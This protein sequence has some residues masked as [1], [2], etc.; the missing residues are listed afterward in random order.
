MVPGM[1]A[2]VWIG[3]FVLTAGVAHA[4]PLAHLDQDVDG[5]GKVDKVTIESSGDLIIQAATRSVLALRPRPSSAEL[6]AATV[7][8]TPMLSA[9]YLAPG[10]DET[11][12]YELRGAVWVQVLREATG[13]VP[14]D[15]DY[16]VA[17]VPAS[18][19]I[20][21][22][23]QRAG[24]HRCDGKPAYLFA[25]GWTGKKFQRL[26]KLPIEV[27]EPAAVLFAKPDP[28][29]PVAPLLYQARVASYEI[30]AQD[31]SALALPTELEDGNPA[32][33]WREELST[34]GEGQFFTF[35]PRAA[36]MKARELRFVAAA[37]KTSV[38]PRRVAVVGAKAAFHI[39]LADLEGAQSVTLPEPI[40]GCVSVV[41]ESAYGGDHGSLAIGELAVYG[42]G[43]RAGGGEATLAHVIAD[44]GDIKTAMQALARRGATAA[45]ALDTELE[46]A[47]SAGARTRL[48][49]ALGE[50]HDPAVGPL[51]EHAIAQSRVEEPELDATLA[52]MGARGFAQELHDLIAK[53][54]LA[55]AHRAAAARALAVA[56]AQDPKADPS[57]LID[58]AGDGS[59]DERK[60]V[61]EGLAR[62]PAPALLGA[63]AAATTPQ[64]AGDLYRAATRRARTTPAERPL[65]VA[66]FTAALA[67]TTDYERRYRLIDGLAA[68]GDPLALEL[69]AK[70]LGS[71]PSGPAGS[72]RFAL[73]HVAADAIAKSPRAEALDLLL[74]CMKEPDP[75]VR[76]AALT[77]LGAAAGGPPGPW[78]AAVDA[79]G[80]DRVIQ[81]SLASDPWPEVR[82]RAA[83]M[84][85]A[86]CSRPGPATSLAD[87]V[88]R[89]PEL[90]VRRDAL[91]ALA[92]CKAAGTGDL[93]AKT[94]DNAR[95]PI[96]L[97]QHAIDLA[98]ELGDRTL[99]TKLLA[100]FDQWRG[101]ALA[102]ADALALTQNA[103]YALGRLAPPGAGA[104]LTGAL[105]DGAF[106][107]IV[108]AAATGLGLMGPA[109]PAG[110][111]K[112]LRELARSE[113]QQ[114]RL[115]A[116]RA[117]A[118]CGK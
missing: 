58:L 47:T 37:S 104:A 87:S 60:A 13:P 66:A 56:L 100:R 75:G 14:P 59:A 110:A 68:V 112:Q 40:A 81:T 41:I 92:E 7:R 91:S 115:A 73:D 80:I 5:D 15:G 118:L 101:A 25:E 9:H 83:Q 61:I 48:V 17:I 29:P 32:T 16:S 22:Y 24:F 95:Q 55:I 107:E 82:A 27:T 106:P 28:G 34:I 4:A 49:R 52:A 93:L 21:R 109:C 50:L 114:V 20:Y 46:K 45:T 67:T 31:A 78:H 89:D 90:G 88:H 96:E 1:R 62:A 70:L 117:A 12:V 85:G 84:L 98:V 19:G 86:R 76:Y 18:A 74:F 94:W 33:A 69:V 38:R 116:A 64:A 26:A 6:V 10:Y 57:L 35:E 103:A 51:L 36:T 71:L 43:E 108:A 53:H 79:D 105:D 54:E 63:A 42:E 113:E 44:G 2:D 3:V 111:S 97:R 65:V 23:Q 39:E 11:A 99:A 72:A 102:S 30:G 8:G 77:A